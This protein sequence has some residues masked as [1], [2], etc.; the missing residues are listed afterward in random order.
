MPTLS[1]AQGFRFVER[2]VAGFMVDLE[3]ISAL[4]LVDF[5][6]AFPEVNPSHIGAALRNLQRRG[7][8]YQCGSIGARG[9]RG[10]LAPIGVFTANMPGDV[11]QW[12]DDTDVMSLCVAMRDGG[13]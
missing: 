12:L 5:F 7:L 1:A 13:A 6:A 11:Q 4:D 2:T 10:R 9:A 8:I 3:T